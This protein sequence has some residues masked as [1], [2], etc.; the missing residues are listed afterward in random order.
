MVPKEGRNSDDWII[1]GSFSGLLALNDHH[2]IYVDTLNIQMQRK[3]DIF[4]NRWRRAVVGL[5]FVL[6]TVALGM[7]RG[8]L[9]SRLELEIDHTISIFLA[10]FDRLWSGC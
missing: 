10:S 1:M 9:Q 7:F 8:T 2:P 5:L 3:I 6:R 4:R